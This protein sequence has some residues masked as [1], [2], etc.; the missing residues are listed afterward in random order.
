[1]PMMTNMTDAVNNVA[2]ALRET[3]PAHVDPD[4]YLAVMEMHGFTT[5]AL[6]VAYTYLLETYIHQNSCNLLV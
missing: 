5:E 1:M 4:L 6:I 2:N 3:R